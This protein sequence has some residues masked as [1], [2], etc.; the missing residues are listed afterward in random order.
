[1][2]EKTYSSNIIGTK[3]LEL[4]NIPIENCISAEFTIKTNS[5]I[6]VTAK[7]YA[8]MDIDPDTKDLKTEMKKYKL[9]FDDEKAIV[10]N[11]HY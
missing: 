7:Y 11:E 9:V 10:E 5:D 1:M 8:S 6:E 2:N 4:L 3:I